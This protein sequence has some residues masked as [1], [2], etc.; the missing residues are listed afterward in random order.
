M[1][2]CDPALVDDDL[3]AEEALAAEAGPYPMVQLANIRDVSDQHAEHRLRQICAAECVGSRR[4]DGRMQ[5]ILLFYGRLCRRED[6]IQAALASCQSVLLHEALTQDACWDPDS[7]DGQ[8][9]CLTQRPDMIAH[10][11]DIVSRCWG[12]DPHCD[13]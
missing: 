7:L 1:A 12:A 6:A 13:V 3:R 9:D 11:V 4:L 5:D 10:M 2:L 8:W